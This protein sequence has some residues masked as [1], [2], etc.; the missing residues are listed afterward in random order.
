[1]PVFVRYWG[2]HFKSERHA[3]KIVT[4]FRPL[5]ERGWRCHLVLE[6]LPDSPA[7]TAA[8]HEMGVVIHCATRPAG[9]FDWRIVSRVA[10]LCRQTGCTVFHCDNMHTSPLIGAWL[11]GVPVRVWWKRSMNAQFEARTADDVRARLVPS[12]RLSCVLST[13]V[14]AVS[15]AIRDE[16]LRLGVTRTRVIVRGNPRPE[17]WDGSAD[18]HHARLS[19]GFSD[20][21]VVILSI[22]HA[23][24]VKGWDLLLRAFGEAAR[25]TPFARLLLAGS[26]SSA[27]EQR[28]MLALAQIVRESAIEGR[29]LFSG[30]VPQIVPLLA[31]A[32]LFVLPSRSE[33]CCNALLE[34]LE[35]GLPSLAT[36][37][38]D[39]EELIVHGVN[40]VLIEREDEAALTQE[41]LRL[42]ADQNWRTQLRAKAK[43]P[44]SVPTQAQHSELAAQLYQHLLSGQCA[45]M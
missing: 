32:D 35:A 16:L 12:V 26:T 23:V 41:L 20:S 3:A 30:H 15:G 40:G 24:P 18:R 9:N 5:I 43:L 44:A 27:E 45:Q 10:S 36:R 8:L 34:A 13:R 39:A 21:E 11:A 25:I 4:S 2:S 22:G 38:G 29:V 1:M 37:V 17:V 19:L 28:H 31:A 7:W 14:V 42:A 33:G 6:R